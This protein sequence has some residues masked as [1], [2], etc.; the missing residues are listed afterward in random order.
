[1]PHSRSPFPT[2]P[3]RVPDPPRP[4]QREAALCPS[5]CSNR[6]PSTRIARLVATWDG[7]SKSGAGLPIRNRV[8]SVPIRGHSPTL[9]VN[10]TRRCN[11]V[12]EMFPVNCYGK[13]PDP[14]A[15]LMAQLI[16][17]QEE[18][19]AIMEVIE[20]LNEEDDESL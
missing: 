10:Q 14:R 15:V 16:D 7:R 13:T 11:L 2:L 1:M 3:V 12:F 18:L 19:E 4:P 5:T 9:S 20:V 6:L 8:P 17:M